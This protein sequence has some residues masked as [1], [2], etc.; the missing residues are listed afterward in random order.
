MGKLWEQNHD[1]QQSEQFYLRRVYVYF[2]YGLA[3]LSISRRKKTKSSNVDR[4]ISV[5]KNAACYN[6]WNY[7]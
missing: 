5:V 6:S 1:A 7:R 2:Y 4:I 3:A